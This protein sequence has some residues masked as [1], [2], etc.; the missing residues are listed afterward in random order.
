MIKQRGK[1]TWGLL[2]K[3]M[4]KHAA[5]ALLS[6]FALLSAQPAA[7][8]TR[9]KDIV[10][11][12][13]VRENQLVGYGLVV[14]LKGTGDRLRNSPFTEVSLKS[15]MERMG[16][17]VHDMDLK[18][19]NVA[20][21]MVTADLPPYARQ[22]SRIDVQVAAMGDATNLQG[23]L[24][25]ATNL[26][27]LNGEVYAV[28]QGSV[29]VSGFEARGAAARVNRGS[30]AAGRV[31]SGA[32]VEREVNFAMGDLSSLKLALK[33]PDFSTASSIAGAINGAVGPGAAVA[34][35]PSTVELSMPAGYRGSIV[36]LVV[37]V[38]Q[39]PISVDQRARI[40]IDEASG[41][42][43]IGENV[44]VSRVAIAQG[45]L[46]ISVAESPIASQ[47]SPF[48]DGETVVLPRTAINVDD[49][50]G[51][52]LAIVDQNVSLRELVDGLNALG[53]TPRDLITILQSLKAA[54]AVQADIEVL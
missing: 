13:G 18:T 46:T 26:M 22:G 1:V 28:A 43:V 10:D 41:T 21:V 16:V 24:L 2:V 3:M 12:E 40:V 9:I 30:T 54:G 44:K 50:E 48:S 20:A 47:P 17:S 6:A 4:I 53:V 19:A 29:A 15:M 52:Q 51:R 39:L 23:G 33:N 32:I 34:L 8:Q 38:E 49:G 42:V 36:D 25:V 7:A 35:D 14:G 11:V 31:A 5:C 27:G 37:A 45:N